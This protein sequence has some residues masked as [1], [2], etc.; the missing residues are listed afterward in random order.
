M[1]A[2][3]AGEG[4]SS[5]ALLEPAPLELLPS[6]TAALAEHLEALLAAGFGLEPFGGETYLLRA[7]PTILGEAEPAGAVA[8]ILDDLQEGSERRSP[9]EE[10]S[11]TALIAAICKRAA[12][13]AGQT[14]SAAEMQALVRGLEQCESPRTCPHGRPTIVHFS[15]EQLEREFLRR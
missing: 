3:A 13:K 1:V 7:V 10:A 9:V 6:Q 4:V 15:V 5:Q 11:E 14:L 8:D 2:Q 12:V